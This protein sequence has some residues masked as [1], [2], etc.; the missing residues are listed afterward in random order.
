MHSYEWVLHDH[1]NSDSVTGDLKLESMPFSSKTGNTMTIRDRRGLRG[2]V[3]SC[4]LERTWLSRRCGADTC[5]T[6]EH[7]DVSDV[8]FRADGSLAREWHRSPD[9]SDWTTTFEYDH[10]GRLLTVRLENAAG[11]VGFQVYEYDTTGRL[12]RL[13]ARDKDGGERVAET[14]AYDIAG[15]K[16]KTLY[17]DLATQR[18]NTHTAWGVEGSDSA[19]SA[20]GAATLTTVYDEREQPTEL[21]F[22]EVQGRLLS[23]VEFRYDEGG[24]LVEEAQSRAEETL[25]RELV[26][27]LNAEQLATVR[28]LFGATEPIRQLHRYDEQGRRTETRSQLGPLGGHRKTV[29]YNDHG[30]QI[31]EVS[32]CETREY[33]ID[34]QGRLS[35][36]STKE[37]VTRSEARFRYNYDTRGNWVEK[38]IEGRGGMD[39]DFAVSSIERRLLAY[40]G[41]DNRIDQR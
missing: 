15:R 25:P 40:Y 3:Q 24:H 32:E 29:A 34:D 20:P 14:Y 31:E 23:R 9:G 36:S 33:A 37:S 13:I 39:Q 18:P 41:E 5:E 10:A 35:D 22:H 26:A 6:E 19:Y 8:E 17:V 38:V 27:E 11:L 28:K 12:A 16:K 1:V 30:D 7:A 21:L 2:P 4:R